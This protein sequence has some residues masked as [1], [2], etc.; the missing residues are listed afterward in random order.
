M[1]PH[2]MKF[3][4]FEKLWTQRV[5]AKARKGKKIIFQVDN[6][7]NGCLIWNKFIY[8]MARE[9]L[10]AIFLPSTC[11]MFILRASNK[12]RSEKLLLQEINSKASEKIAIKL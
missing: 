5:V 3:Y 6:E 10:F 7:L 4:L 11:V 9:C 1:S 8:M 12:R 2:N